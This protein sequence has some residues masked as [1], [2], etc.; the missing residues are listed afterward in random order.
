MQKMNKKTEQTL[1]KY[2]EKHTRSF[3][4]QFDLLCQVLGETRIFDKI[5]YPTLNAMHDPLVLHKR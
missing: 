2:P 4:G 3:L 1:H 5:K